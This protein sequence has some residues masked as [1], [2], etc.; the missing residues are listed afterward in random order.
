MLAVFDVFTPQEPSLTAD[1]IMERLTYS[2][3][4]AYRY[5]KELTS[6]GLL[7]RIG[8]AYSLGPRIVELDYFIRENDPHLHIIQPVLRAL[9]DRLE[10]D[11]LWMSFFGDHVVTTHHERG[12]ST[13]TVSFGRGRRMP[14]FRGA[15][16]K[17]IVSALPHAQLK[18]LYQSN[19][20]EAEAAGLG[21][22]W[23]EFRANMTAIRRAGHYISRG[24]LDLGSVGIAA[25]I[26]PDAP[27]PP[28]SIVL[29][30]SEK[31]HAIADESLLVRIIM[32]AASQ[33]SAMIAGGGDEGNVRWLSSRAS[34]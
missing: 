7:K 14:L 5:I 1:E 2:R 16:S 17:V 22:S 33:V 15:P 8:G 19:T 27:H 11:V 4:T 13:L 31:R 3:G 34:A 28:G 29:V 6:A 12:A 18:R 20:A 32:D 24:E 26:L 25:P 9:S 21:Q 23:K 30:L 10:C